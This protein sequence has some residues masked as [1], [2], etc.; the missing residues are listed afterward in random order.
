MTAYVSVRREWVTSGTPHSL[1]VRV[2]GVGGFLMLVT[3]AATV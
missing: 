1:L 2:L 3:N